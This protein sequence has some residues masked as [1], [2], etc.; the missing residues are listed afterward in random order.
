MALPPRDDRTGA[1]KED[2]VSGNIA[3]RVPLVLGFALVFTAGCS[4]QSRLRS[5]CTSGDV[6]ACVQLG[7]MYAAGT[8]V[9]RDMGRAAEMYQ[10]ACDQGAAEVCNTLGEIYERGL[11]LE[12]GVDRAEQ[13]FRL[14][15]NGN[16]AAGCLNLG[17]VLSARDDKKGA[18]A[19]FERSCTAGWTPGCHHLALA[20]EHGDGLLPDLERA[21]ALYD[22]ACNEKYVDS[23]LAA[24][25][26]FVTGER[27]PRDVQRATRY[28][29]TA[30]KTYDERCDA[31]SASDCK[32]RD[33]LRT[34]V[35]VLASQ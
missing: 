1:G 21:V 25:N 16:S 18:A 23:C 13:M 30:L 15:C 12:G 14:A 24:A 31:G 35:A 17:L 19:L 28:Y 27:L 7:D 10:R 32:E 6:A 29:G 11:E 9:T 33:R 3:F 5:R 22:D 20:L 26:L 2:L 4:E 8:R 34:R